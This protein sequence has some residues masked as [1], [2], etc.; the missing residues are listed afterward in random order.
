MKPFINNIEASNNNI[1]DAMASGSHCQLSDIDPASLTNILARLD[2]RSL[3]SIQSLFNRQLAAASR[4]PSVWLEQL[5]R[6]WCLHLQA[7]ILYLPRHA[8][9]AP[10]LSLMLVCL[11]AEAL[12]STA[13]AS[14]PSNSRC[15]F[16]CCSKNSHQA[17]VDLL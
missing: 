4:S 16:L 3:L 9:V 5:Q 1:S 13:F 2:V 7:S 6:D 10:P 12:P 15:T 8:P 14:S 17:S 11:P